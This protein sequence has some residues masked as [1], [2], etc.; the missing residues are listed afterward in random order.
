MAITL[1]TVPTP[2]ATPIANNAASAKA[3][4]NNYYK[5]VPP[6]VSAQDRNTILI[7]GM[8]YALAASAGA[9]YKAK[10]DQL[11]Q[12]ATVYT[13]G[14]SDHFDFLAALAATTWSSGNT[15]D[16]TLSNDIPTLLGQATH[17]QAQPESVQERIIAFLA[18]QLG[19]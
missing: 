6:S 4:A 18:A 7:L 14:I 19:I 8:I 11:I 13:G 10:Q 9:N 3:F 5:L 2:G 15:L 16:P 17:I 12:D 1:Q